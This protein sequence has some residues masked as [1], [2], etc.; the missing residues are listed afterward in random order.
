MTRREKEIDDATFEFLL[1]YPLGI[2]HQETVVREVF[3]AGA[4]WADEHPS[5]SNSNE[6][7][8]VH[9]I[10][11]CGNIS[12]I[13]FPKEIDWTQI[14]SNKKGSSIERIF[15]STYEFN[16]CRC[17]QPIILTLRI[18]EYPEGRIAKQDIKVENGQIFGDYDLES[19]FLTNLSDD[20]QIS[21]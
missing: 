16:C 14:E 18:V 1:S 11:N 15:E 9:C 5:I 4:K 6:D 20:D 17:N 3:K 19:L 21:M 13:K 7:I 10:C 12:L 2:K 8:Y